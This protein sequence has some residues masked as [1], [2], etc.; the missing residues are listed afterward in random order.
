KSDVALPPLKSATFQTPH[1]HYR[2][3]ATK[4]HD[5]NIQTPNTRHETQNIAHL[6]QKLIGHGA[7]GTS[8]WQLEA[9]IS[10]WLF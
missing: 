10:V 8:R 9:G 4:D 5:A 2:E 3:P 7:R 1:V 6:H